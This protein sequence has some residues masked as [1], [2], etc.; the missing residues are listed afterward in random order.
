MV[1]M[2]WLNTLDTTQ[3]VNGDQPYGDYWIKVPDRPDAQHVY[4]KGAWA[5]DPALNKAAASVGVNA[6]RDTQMFAGITY[7][8]HVYD[9]DERSVS[10]LNATITLVDGGLVLP[11]GFVWRTQDNVNVP[12]AI[13]DLKGLA[14]AML[15]NAY[16]LYAASWA[17][18]DAM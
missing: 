17:Q 4:V 7:A 12:M 15:L 14:Q 1:I 9:S 11:P 2:G 5:L 16:A 10:N 3:Y 18:K 13:A 6:T 8:G